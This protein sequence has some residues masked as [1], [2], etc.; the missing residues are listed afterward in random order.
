MPSRRPG[1]KTPGSRRESFQDTYVIVR[2][3]ERRLMFYTAERK[4]N[5]FLS[6]FKLSGASFHTLFGVQR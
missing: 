6:L 1:V 2:N 4:R 5:Y 3:T